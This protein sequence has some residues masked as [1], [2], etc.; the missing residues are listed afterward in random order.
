[1]GISISSKAGGLMI[2][3]TE[4]E[5][6]MRLAILL[7]TAP[8]WAKTKL[9]SNL[10]HESDRGADVIARHI[11]ERLRGKREPSERSQL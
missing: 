1:M 3:I 11:V 8:L 6:E 9:R 7:R 4:D 5:L 2:H 10:P